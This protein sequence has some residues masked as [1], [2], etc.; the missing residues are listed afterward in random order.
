MRGQTRK[1]SKLKINMK[2]LV[3]TIIGLLCASLIL[4][5]A[6][7][8]KSDQDGGKPDKSDTGKHKDSNKDKDSEN[9]NHS[10]KHKNHGKHKGS[11]KH[12]DSGKDK[13]SKE[14]SGTDKDSDS[15]K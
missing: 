10:G 14:K 11:E 15:N 8:N 5:H 6:Q 4:V 7:D 1:L 9:G 13:G 2:K 3:L 12:N